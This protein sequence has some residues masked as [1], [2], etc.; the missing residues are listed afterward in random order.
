MS[1]K[2]NWVCVIEKIDILPLIMLFRKMPV[3]TV[4]PKK[5]SQYFSY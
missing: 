3:K 2:G 5:Q 4:F 1:G